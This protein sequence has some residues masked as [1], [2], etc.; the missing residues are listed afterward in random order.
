MNDQISG[1]PKFT[2]ISFTMHVY[3]P[4]KRLLDLGNVGSITEKFCLDA[5]VELGKL[6]DDNYLFVPETHTYFKGID[7]DNPRVDII[8]KEL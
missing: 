7:K 4:N 1:L 5:L 6:E 3:A 8:I 2:K